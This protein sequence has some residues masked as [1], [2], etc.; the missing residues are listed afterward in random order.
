MEDSDFVDRKH[1][2]RE[3]I[4]NQKRKDGRIR[5]EDYDRKK[6]CKKAFKQKKQRIKEEETEE[7]LNDYQ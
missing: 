2:R 6:L 4:I 5:D 1:S 3:N 7:D